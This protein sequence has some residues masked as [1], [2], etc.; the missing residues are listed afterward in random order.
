M[1]GG[2][3]LPSL[4]TYYQAAHLHRIINW[5]A[6]PGPKRWVTLETEQTQGGIPS[7]L[8]LGS[9]TY[10]DLQTTN[11]IIDATLRVWCTLRYAQQ[12]TT[13]PNP[14]TPITFNPD[15]AG[16]LHPAAL[17]HF[18]ASDWNYLHQWSEGGRIRSLR[19][20]M[21]DQPPTLLESFHY[22]QVQKLGDEDFGSTAWD[23]CDYPVPIYGLVTALR[24]PLQFENYSLTFFKEL[25][26]SDIGLKN[27]RGMEHGYTQ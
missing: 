7:R 18:H 26:E 27:R 4:L 11:P 8:W 16:G 25:M 19:D 9:A 3:G 17:T 5:H 10:R 15:L 21:G 22:H 20:L 13:S 24:T 14:L 6:C 2:V 23:T 1:E 12:L